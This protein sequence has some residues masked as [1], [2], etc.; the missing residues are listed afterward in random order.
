MESVQPEIWTLFPQNAAVPAV[1]HALFSVL[2][3]PREAS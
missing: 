3:T 1:F 2:E